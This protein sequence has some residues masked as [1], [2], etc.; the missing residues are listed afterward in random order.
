MKKFIIEYKIFGIMNV[1]FGEV[2]CYGV[3]CFFL[4]N[5]EF[6]RVELYFELLVK[7]YNYI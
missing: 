6:Y 7:I 4:W 3:Y 2:F 1:S 5:L